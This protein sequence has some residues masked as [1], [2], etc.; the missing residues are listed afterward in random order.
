VAPATVKVM[1]SSIARVTGLPE[2]LISQKL[3]CGAYSVDECI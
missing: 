2:I 3:K 1:I